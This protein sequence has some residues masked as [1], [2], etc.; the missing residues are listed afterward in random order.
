M[1]PTDKLL[2]KTLVA[3]GIDSARWE[4]VR[5]GL[6]DRAFFS[7]KVESLRYLHTAREQ[8]AALLASATRADGAGVTRASAI[9]AIMEEARRQGIATGGG[10]LTDPGSARRA[11]LI[12]DT[13]AGLAAGYCAREK[14]L[15]Y[16]ARLA[17]PAQEFLRVAKRLHPRGDWP[18]RWAAAGGRTY[19]GR[20]VAL[21][22]DPVWARVSRFGLPHPPFDYGSGMGVRP[23]PRREAAALG[24]IPAGYAPPR[25]IPP[26]ED[27]NARL[28]ADLRWANDGEWQ[29]LKAAFGDQVVK[30][31]DRIAFRGNAIRDRILSGKPFRIELGAPTRDLVSKVPDPSIVAP[32]APLTV[33]EGWLSKKRK[34]EATDHR[35]HFGHIPEHP[36][37]IPLTLSD[38][39]LIPVI[40]RSPDR[41]LPGGIGE[42]PYVVVLEMDALAGG[43]YR[44]PVR[45]GPKPKLLS[46]YRTGPEN[47]KG[48]AAG[49]WGFQYTAPRP[50]EITPDQA[51]AA[52]DTTER[53][54]GQ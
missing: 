27:F 40:W 10:G 26:Q 33:T 17:F 24:V 34:D 37:D 52:E 32:G 8:A 50:D 51:D 28:E 35:A 7:S 14:A 9:S 12:I 20:M 45:L 25:E 54:R 42:N 29:E 6:R 21:V 39:D 41:V 44:L 15:S 49:P 2:Q 3:S 46:F 30:D 16:G 5:A 23:V 22:T 1:T 19:G 47:G 18:A 36:D 13:N 4:S 48:K 43:T 31:G 53:K 11:A 38:V